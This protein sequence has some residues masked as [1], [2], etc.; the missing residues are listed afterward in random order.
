MERKYELVLAEVMKAYA[1]CHMSWERGAKLR[2]LDF[3]ASMPVPAPVAAEIMKKAVPDGYNAFSA[4]I[5]SKIDGEVVIAREG[6]VCVYVQNGA[7]IPK[8]LMEDERSVTENGET[9]L[10]WD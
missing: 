7:Y 3:R 5:L 2:N 9:R 6:S 8:P 10:W 1:D 4:Q